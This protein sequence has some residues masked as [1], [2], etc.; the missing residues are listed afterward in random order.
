MRKVEIRQS[1]L[2]TE[3]RTNNTNRFNTTQEKEKHLTIAQYK[4]KKSEKYYT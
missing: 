1:K 4:P 3:R 2:A